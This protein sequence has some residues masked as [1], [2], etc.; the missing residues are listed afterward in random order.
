MSDLFMNIL[1]GLLA[2]GLF[3]AL[4]YQVLTH[5]D[6]LNFRSDLFMDNEDY[7]EAKTRLTLAKAEREELKLAQEK[8]ELLSREQVN[9]TWA[10]KVNIVKNKILSIPELAPVLINH[11][12]GEIKSIL[13]GK[14]R[15]ILNELANEDS[16]FESMESAS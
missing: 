9:L 16:G 7:L 15:E 1:G 4:F 3:A 6:D 10:E 2:F 11:T 8:H 13:N 14:T 5:D 12:A